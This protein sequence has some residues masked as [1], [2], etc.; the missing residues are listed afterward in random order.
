MLVHFNPRSP[1]GERQAT[2]NDA[3][4]S[5]IFQ[6]TLPVWGATCRY[7]LDSNG[8]VVFQ[9]TLPVWGATTDN[10]ALMREQP[11]QSTLPVWGA[12]YALSGH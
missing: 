4:W 9:S 6:S 5:K 10:K 3:M 1:C 7:G 2:Y 11:F 8:E 12:T